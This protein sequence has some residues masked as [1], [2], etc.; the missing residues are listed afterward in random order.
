MHTTILRAAGVLL[1]LAIAAFGMAQQPAADTVVL[2]VN[3][4]P[5]YYWEVAVTLPQVQ[6][7]MLRQG[8][9]PERE[10]VVSASMKRVVDIHLLGEEARRLG[11]KP[12][13]VRV[14]AAMAQLIEQAGG[15]ENFDATLAQM[16]IT[17]DELKMSATE[18]DLVQVYIDTVIDPQVTVTADEV[19]TFYNQNPEMFERPEMVRALHIMTRIN[20]GA[21]QAEKDAARGRANAA[22]QRVLNGE[23]FATVATEVSEGREAANGG[24]L[25]FFAREG[26]VPAIADAAFSLDIGQVSQVA[27]SQ[28]GYHVIKVMEKR[29][30]SKMTFDE[31][32][33]PLEQ[34]LREN[35]GGELVAG[36]L[37]ELNEKATIVEM[38][39]PASAQ[40]NAGG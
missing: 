32:K 22:R 19:V 25:G 13:P 14:E 23:D 16:G 29:D 1:A 36:K 28:F 2:K 12:D 30:A 40:S 6:M 34:M 10:M 11:L 24:D 7:E 18:S 3:D 15:R 35:K 5:I 17:S 37:A 4:Q 39:P 8:I 38:A 9:Q 26:M 27:E 33:E 21:D 20:P 31:T